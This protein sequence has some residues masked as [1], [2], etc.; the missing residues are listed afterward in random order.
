MTFKYIFTLGEGRLS[1]Y[2][3]LYDLC[4]IPFDKII[5]KNLQLKHGFQPLPCTWSRLDP[6]PIYLQRQEWVREK[7]DLV[8]P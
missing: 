7:F 3:H 6:Y 4:H 2:S 8:P 5:I 1:G